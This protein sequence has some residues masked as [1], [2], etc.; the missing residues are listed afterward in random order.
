LAAQQEFAL[1][2]GASRYAMTF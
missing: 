2:A 1:V